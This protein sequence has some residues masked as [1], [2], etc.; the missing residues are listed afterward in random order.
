MAYGAMVAYLL[1]IKDTVPTLFGVPQGNGGI[2]R[3]VI[4]IGTSLLVI[5]PLSM[6]RVRSICMCC[7]EGINTFS[8]PPSALNPAMTSSFIFLQD[9]AT[10][11]FTSAL[12]V[13]ADLILVIF[14]LIFSPI[15]ETVAAAGGFSEIL[16]QDS[17]RP[18]LFIGL[19]V[20]ST[21]MACQ[22]S[23]FIV[24]GS[25]ER[26]TRA[27]WAFVTGWSIALSTLLCTTLGTA[28]YLGFL[29]ETQG[30][31]LNNFDPD[32]MTAN[33]AR[34]L[35]AI[36]MFFT[37]RQ[38]CSMKDYRCVVVDVAINTYLCTYHCLLLPVHLLG[39]LRVLISVPY[40]SFRCTAR[41]FVAHVP[42][43]VGGDRRHASHSLWYK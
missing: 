6:Q 32:S 39:R 7:N 2:G 29:E 11:C 41:V 1:I 24:S 26:L 23:A 42:R 38:F 19:G 9:M 27:R 30:D 12:S 31:V 34:A 21:A 3:E 10:L 4:L 13:T 28:G 43:R 8:L 14:I 18:T 25:L 15:Q 16:S 33:A 22:H 5:L 17:I 37:V 40:G 35:L 20:L 36:T